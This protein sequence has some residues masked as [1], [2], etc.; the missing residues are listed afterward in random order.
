MA[1]PD[2][3]ELG[4][5]SAALRIDTDRLDSYLREHIA[6]YAG[7]GEVRQF[8]GGQSNPTYLIE[9]ASGNY[10]LRKKPPGK[11]LPSAHAVDREYR[12]I[13]ALTD[14]AVPVPRARL[15]CED[16]S[17]IGQTFYVMN[18]VSGRV[19]PGRAPRG[20]ACSR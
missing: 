6:G 9:D 1:S 7:G 14:S 18:Y 13:S 11:L 5:P 3:R 10:V 17:V 8:L 4:A 16:D 2:N 20:R 12:V 19:F 15:L